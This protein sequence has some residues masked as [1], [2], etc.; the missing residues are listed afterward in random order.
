MRT[1]QSV[2]H[3]NNIYRLCQCGIDNQWALVAVLKK[4]TIK[5]QDRCKTCGGLLFLK[6]LETYLFLPEAMSV[7][8]SKVNC[9][10]GKHSPA[11]FGMEK[12]KM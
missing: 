6:G 5:K 11:A 1:S 3:V 9:K 8:T 10:E 4:E 2:L 7:G 12:W